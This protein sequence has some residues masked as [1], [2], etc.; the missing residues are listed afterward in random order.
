MGY[1]FASVVS[2][3]P[4]PDPDGVRPGGAGMGDDG[5][6]ARGAHPRGRDG[7]REHPARRRRGGDALP[8]L[9]A[10]LDR[11]ADEELRRLGFT[12]EDRAL[13]LL[14]ALPLWSMYVG[15]CGSSEEDAAEMLGVHVVT[16]GAWL[17]TVA[18]WLV[19][20]AR[21]ATSWCLTVFP[22][23]PFGL[24]GSGLLETASRVPTP[25]LHTLLV[26]ARFKASLQAEGGAR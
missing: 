10:E 3:D 1:G 16:L 18:D 25:S 12:R 11:Q 22:S 14:A 17:R 21:P 5:G 23:R 9:A 20:D 2:T 13:E 7:T 4:D 8:S 19:R 15:S 26:L 6:A 24:L